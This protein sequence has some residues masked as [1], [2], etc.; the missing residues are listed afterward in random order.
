[1]DA[2]ALRSSALYQTPTSSRSQRGRNVP[3]A[4]TT[5]DSVCRDVVIRER[6][7]SSERRSAI[8]AI[9]YRGHPQATRRGGP[10]ARPSLSTGEK[11]DARAV[12][13]SS[14]GHIPAPTDRDI[15]GFPS[16]TPNSKLVSCHGCKTA[17][18]VVLHEPCRSQ[19]HR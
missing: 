12:H 8:R 17:C 19:I 18:V 5:N 3:R 6:C 10:L 11:V 2:F 1:M 9:T 14:F 4:E 16:S 7:F 15:T 13:F